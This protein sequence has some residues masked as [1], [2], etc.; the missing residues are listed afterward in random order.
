[1]AKQL[2]DEK[3]KQPVMVFS[4]TYCPFCKMAKE[5]LNGTGKPYDVCELDERGMYWGAHL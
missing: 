2:V 3:I 4:K 5:A 1:M